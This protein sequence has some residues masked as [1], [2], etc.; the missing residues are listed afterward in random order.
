MTDPKLLYELPNLPVH[1]TDDFGY[2]HFSAVSD[3][4]KDKY[5]E[6]QKAT[7]IKFTLKKGDTLIIPKKWWHWVKS[8][9]RTI[10]INNWYNGEQKDP[11]QAKFSWPALKI[12]TDRY[13]L[14]T[15]QKEVYTWDTSDHQTVK[16][17]FKQ[18][19]K[20]K[21]KH[22]YI[23]SL[24]AYKSGENNELPKKL[25]EYINFEDLIGLQYNVWIA[26]NDVETGLHY[27]DQEGKIFVISGTKE[28]T[29]YSPED[30]VYIPRYDITPSWCVPSVRFQYNLYKLLPNETSIKLVPSSAL[31]YQSLKIGDADRIIYDAILNLFKLFQ[32]GQLIFGIKN[33]IEGNLR[34]EIYFYLTKKDPYLIEQTSDVKYTW[35]NLFFQKYGIKNS[36]VPETKNLTIFSFDLYPK[37]IN[38][39]IHLYYIENTELKLP[40][41][42]TGKYI[43]Q[44]QLKDESVFCIYSQE[45]AI[46][47]LEK[48]N[49]RTNFK[50]TLEQILKY[51]AKTVSCYNKYNGRSA[52]QYYGISQADFISFLEEYNWNKNFIE[53]YKHNLNKY[54]DMEHEITIN[55]LNGKVIGTSIYGMI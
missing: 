39:E 38:D 25:A 48:I 3:L 44:N 34:W 32:T 26:F 2:A 47:D 5:P 22:K 14:D 31:L 24:P 7:P 50:F 1:L 42:G 6:F 51:K 52:I 46:Q 45:T 20:N 35:N 43:K 8:Y 40:L 49:L 55:Y 16:T 15:I 4:N 37:Y 9:G 27:D 17:S 33:S 13:L 28:V 10:S 23:V 54:Q 18:F 29:L 12:W 21:E 11:V 19:I 36:L 41:F 53:F 30:T